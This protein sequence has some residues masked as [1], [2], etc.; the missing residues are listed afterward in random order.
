[1]SEPTITVVVIEDDKHIRRF[2]HTSLE[3]DGMTV[4]DA[5][6]GEQGLAQAATRRPDLV[7]VDLGLPDMNGIDVIRELRNWSTVPVVV[8]SARNREEDKVAALDAG[9]DDYL[10][11]PFG[12][13]ELNAR[14]RAHLRRQ[15]RGGRPESTT[16]HFGTV[17]VDLAERKVTRDN[18]IIHLTPIEYRLLSVLV[19]RA[20]WVLTHRQLLQEVWGP[21]HTNNDHYLRVY[22]GHLRHKL[23][24][25][26]AQPEHIVTE[27]GVGYRLVGLIDDQ[28]R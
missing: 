24:H 14:I 27:T 11:K 5:E 12:L 28:G 7:I 26:P 1:M 2:V 6:T 21:T 4:F 15:T 20:G 9:A 16:V 3:A 18:Q 25:D 22:M 17:T 8:L 23:E 10:T 19:S 13:P